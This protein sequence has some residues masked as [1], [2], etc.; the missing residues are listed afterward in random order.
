MHV[1]RAEKGF[2]IVGQD[3]DGSVTPMDLDHGW[4]VNN[5][6]P[7]SFIGKR[8]M[9]REDCVRDNRKQL[10]GLK[11]KKP[12][13]VLPEGAQAVELGVDPD[14]VP[15]PMLGHV[16][17]SYFSTAL[18][19]SI[20]MALIKGGLDRYGDTVAFPLLDGRIVHAEICSPNFYDPNNDVQKG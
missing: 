19:R 16:T 4:A 5:N 7:F 10:V 2:I 8:G 20:A 1:L 9:A 18:D 13:V 6:K 15:V 14:D 12:E 3:T 17:S 11:T